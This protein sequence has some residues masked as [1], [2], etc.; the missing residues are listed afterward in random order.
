MIYSTEM[1][2]SPFMAI[3][4]TLVNHHSDTQ[5]EG[6]ELLSGKP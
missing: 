6:L 3:W 4:E 5:S 2:T 1:P